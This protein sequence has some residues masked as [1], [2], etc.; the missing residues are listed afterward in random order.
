MIAT[1]A[2]TTTGIDVLGVRW[3][4]HRS[5]TYQGGGLHYG[6]RYTAALTCIP[7][8][9]EASTIVSP[10]PISCPS[11]FRLEMRSS[12]VGTV[13]TELLPSQEMVMGMTPAGGVA[14]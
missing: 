1:T 4:S 5:G 8:P 14:P 3:Q 9:T 12:S 2:A 10:L 11:S 7:A 6:A 13:A